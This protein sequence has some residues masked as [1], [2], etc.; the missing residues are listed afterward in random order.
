MMTFQELRLALWESKAVAVLEKITAE[1]PLP[2]AVPSN[3]AVSSN[4]ATR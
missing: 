4:G 2:A 3:G 1:H